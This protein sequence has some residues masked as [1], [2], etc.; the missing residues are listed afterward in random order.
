MVISSCVQNI[1]IRTIT[2]YRQKFG[3]S[4]IDE[5]FKSQSKTLFNPNPK[6]CSTKTPFPNTTTSDN[7]TLTQTVT[8]ADRQTN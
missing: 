7:Q 4:K 8:W 6:R 3:P 2:Y 5:N 1:G